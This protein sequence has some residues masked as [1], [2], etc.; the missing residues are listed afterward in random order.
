MTEIEMGLGTLPEPWY[1]RWFQLKPRTWLYIQHQTGYRQP[2]AR[3]VNDG[4]KD[5]WRWMDQQGAQIASFV[6][7]LLDA[8]RR[9]MSDDESSSS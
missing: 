7:S 3:F 8:E 9:V 1:R 6:Q 5:Y 4:Q 2:V